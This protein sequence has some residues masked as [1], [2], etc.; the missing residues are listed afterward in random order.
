MASSTFSCPHCGQSLPS[1]A[2]APPVCPRC[3]QTVRARA[4]ADELMPPTRTPPAP[5]PRPPVVAPPAGAASPVVPPP[6]A[7]LARPLPQATPLPAGFLLSDKNDRAPQ[8]PAQAEGGFA[9]SP[10]VTA[11]APAAPGNVPPKTRKVGL[12]RWNWSRWCSAAPQGWPLAISLSFGFS[13]AMGSRTNGPNRDTRRLPKTSRS[14]SRS[15]SRG[16]ARCPRRRRLRLLLLCRPTS[17]D[18]DQA[19]PARRRR[20][21]RPRHSPMRRLPRSR[22]PRRHGLRP[23]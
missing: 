8:H 6:I 23:R 11:T 12:G 4:D 21:R 22:L 3:G 1:V 15:S 16:P 7:A 5:A 9:G 20:A 10:I 17:V 14:N 18:L 2:G 13:I 19:K